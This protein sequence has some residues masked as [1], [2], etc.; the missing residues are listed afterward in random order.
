ML[1]A[2]RLGA[3]LFLFPDEQSPALQEIRYLFNSLPVS[4]LPDI[5]AMVRE[6]VSKGEKFGRLVIV[7]G[8][9]EFGAAEGQ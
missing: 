3:A 9:D 2:G 4:H 5:E 7:C 1:L 8:I 6:E